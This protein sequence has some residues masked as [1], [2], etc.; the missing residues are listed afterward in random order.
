[1]KHQCVYSLQRVITST[2]RLSIAPLFVLTIAAS[3]RCNAQSK[4]IATGWDSPN[5]SEFRRHV[6]EFEKWPFDGVT[7][8]PTIRLMNGTS[9]SNGYAFNRDKWAPDACAGMTADL[10]AVHSRIK[11]HSFLFCYANPGD[12]DWFDDKGWAEIV[13]HWRQL[14]RTARR[15]NL[16]GLLFDAEPY[17]PP[18][19]QFNEGL[20]SGAKQHSFEEYAAKAR[21][22]GR[23]VM[24]AAAAEYPSMTLFT[25]R[26][27]SDLL[28]LTG[29]G[30]DPRTAL[31]GNVWALLPAFVDGWLDVAPPTLVVVEGD[32]DIG[33]RANSP[34]IFDRAYARLR[35]EIPSLLDPANRGKYRSQV[36]ISHGL[37][38][39]AYVN[40][41]GNAWYI[42]PLGGTPG[43]RLEANAAA[44]LHASDSG[45]VWIYGE[46]GRWWP[47]RE[48]SA[49]IPLWTERLK[50]AEVALL[51]AKDP[52]AAA[53]A[54]LSSA[55]NAPN[56]LNNADF[57][58][59]GKEGFPAGWW[60]W[61]DD[62]SHGSAGLESN[63]FRWA[64]AARAAL[65]QN[66]AVNPGARHAIS[67]QVRRSGHGSASIDVG[68]K[69]AQGRWL[70][71]SEDFL[72]LPSLAAG[73]GGW[74]E[75]SGIVTAPP[76]SAEMVIMFVVS[77]QAVQED[78]AQCRK[79]RCLPLP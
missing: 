59:S 43:A 3:A 71:R 41:P 4:L 47:A 2:I 49:P 74:H 58:L 24:R 5:A 77:G 46:A 30:G 19:Q 52:A 61:Q 56:E 8:F 72:L 55:H 65:G 6:G 69:D 21:A 12:V 18:F 76:D 64:G 16:R 13:D 53:S 57:A 79:F 20:Q 60:L 39:D 10:Q 32:E 68:W 34:A 26:L 42:D 48:G 17:T 29:K 22:R 35:T 78:S 50:G 9:I 15:G 66:V 40:S 51:R 33:Y 27:L 7:I 67:A 31:S 38:L 14:A 25:Y 28:P 23:E 70:K 54:F 62:K 1:M 75:A 45:Y 63:S 44:A 37:Y 36:L 11:A 73:A